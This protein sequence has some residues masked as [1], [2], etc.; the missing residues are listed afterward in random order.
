[1]RIVVRIEK[2]K[3]ERR[4]NTGRRNEWENM[5]IRLKRREEDRP[6]KLE[7]ELQEFT[8][9]LPHGDGLRSFIVGQFN[10][11]SRSKTIEMREE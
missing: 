10:P 2:E 8:A 4:R 6:D 1:M 9:H 7:Y 3:E 11:P 5:R